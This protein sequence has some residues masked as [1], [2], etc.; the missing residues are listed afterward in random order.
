MPATPAK[1]SE[2]APIRSPYLTL[3]LAW[4]VPGLGHYL[5]GR[6]GR[7]LIIFCTV[8][9]TFVV[10]LLMRGPMFEPTS[11]GDVLSRVIQAAGFVGDLAV[12]LFYFIA[13]W[14][15]YWPPD[16]ASHLADYGSKFLVAAGL[17]N[18]LALVDVYEINSRQK[19]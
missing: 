8:V 5:L 3:V 7:A 10:G 6:K 12:G 13:I 4:L 1:V 19:E 11:A 15:G 16:R 18:I 2:T 17:L 14:F 9:L